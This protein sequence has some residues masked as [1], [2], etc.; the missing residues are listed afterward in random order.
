MKVVYSIFSKLRGILHTQDGKRLLESLLSLGAL[1]IIAYIFPLITIP[2][3]SKTIGVDRFG[4]LALAT[5]MIMYFQVFVDWGYNFIG[6]REVARYREDEE[7]VSHIY[8]T[9]FWGRLFLISVSLVIVACLIFFVPRLQLI[10]LPLAF[11]FL[12]IV[13]YWLYADWLFQGLEEMRYITVLNLCSNIFFTASVFLFIK[14]PE[15]YVYHPLLMS[16][17][18]VISGLFSFL[19]VT[20]RKGIRLRIIPFKEVL[21]SL[22]QSGNIFFNQ[23]TT[24]YF[25]NIVVLFLGMWHPSR[26]NGLFDAGSKPA[27]IILR[28][29]S[30][31]SRAFY[32]LLAR[33]I[34]KHNLFVVV[35]LIVAS[36]LSLAAFLAAPLIVSLLFSAEFSE[37][38]IALRI[39]LPSIVFTTLINAYGINYLVQ[40]GEERRLRNTTFTGI[41]FS[42]LVAIPFI[43]FYSWIGAALTLLVSKLILGVFIMFQGLKCKRNVG[44]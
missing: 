20:P 37:A 33:R 24:V 3:L 7:K 26:A 32:P 28:F 31:L 8:S 29:S 17:G 40:I 39:I 36:V 10:A 38:V 25:D 6:T 14:S 18:F 34:D 9:V 12:I 15:D 41:G 2:Y 19:G 30:V 5:A 13:G 11:R 1:E 44:N 16:M 43:Y 22:K 21:Q 23:A 4:D 42:F 27:A 35:S